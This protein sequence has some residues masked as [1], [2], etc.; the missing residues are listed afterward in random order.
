MRHYTNSSDHTIIKCDCKA[1]KHEKK[2][3]N[4]KRK[5]RE[6]SSTYNVA[7]F[8]RVINRVSS[9]NTIYAWSVR[10]RNQR[11]N[12]SAALCFSPPLSL[13]L[14]HLHPEP[15]NCS[16]ANHNRA[17]VPQLYGARLLRSIY[18]RWRDLVT[19]FLSLFR[20]MTMKL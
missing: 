11:F 4:P 16:L 20:Y 10:V 3:Q 6:Y 9:E 13:S 19:L 17:S 7:I 15:R 14:S 8:S 18:R 1:S 12:S 5:S 2:P